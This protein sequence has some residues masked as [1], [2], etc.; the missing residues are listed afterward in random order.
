MCL[1][2]H[3]VCFSLVEPRGSTAGEEM[4]DSDPKCNR[5]WERRRVGSGVYQVCTEWSKS[6]ACWPRKHPPWSCAAR[7]LSGTG[8]E[9]NVKVHGGS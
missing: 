8:K 6:Q 4:M 3:L 5:M 1:W 7:A 9:I 2:M